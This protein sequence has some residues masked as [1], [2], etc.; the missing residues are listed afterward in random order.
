MPVNIMMPEAFAQKWQE[1]NLEDNK[2]VSENLF[3]VARRCKVN[4]IASA[5]LLQGTLLQLPLDSTIFKCSNL[6]AKHLQFVRSIPAQA[7]LSK[8]SYI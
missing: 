7:L 6:G 8:L 2:K 4:V 1:F 5:P 3:Q